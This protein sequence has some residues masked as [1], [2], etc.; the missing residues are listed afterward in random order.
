[1]AQTDR[2]ETIWYC[3]CALDARL[4][5]LQSHTLNAYYLILLH[6]TK[7]TLAFLSVMLQNIPDLLFIVLFVVVDPCAYYYVI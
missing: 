6:T 4:F 2:P 7:F 5:R 1:M 3:A